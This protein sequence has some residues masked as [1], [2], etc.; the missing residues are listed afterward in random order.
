MKKLIIAFSLVSLLITALLV[1]IIKR[2]VIV[3]P[4]PLIKPTL[5][6][7]DFEPVARH[8]AL[9][10][11]P[12]FQSNDYIFW[13][14]DLN[15]I[16]AQLFQ[17]RIIEEYTKLFQKSVHVLQP[18]Q[19]LDHCG[20]PCWIFSKIDIQSLPSRSIEFN[21]INYDKIE[22]IP[23]QCMNKKILDFECIKY[24]SLKSVERKIKNKNDRYFFLHKYMDQAFYLFVK[25]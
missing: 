6:Q 1:V 5:I 25:N 21:W 13:N 24:V 9:R 3:R 22:S 16:E 14:L 17:K 18:D 20:Q 19:S 12:E 23:D 15:N 7:N 8:V 11:F 4:Q 2:G 10:M